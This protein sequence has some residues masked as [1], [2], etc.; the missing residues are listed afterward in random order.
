MSNDTVIIFQCEAVDKIAV[1]IW[2][3]NENIEDTFYFL[4]KLVTK[5]R[6]D[7]VLKELIKSKPCNLT[8]NNIEELKENTDKKDLIILNFY[9]YKTFIKVNDMEIRI[10]F[11]VSRQPEKGVLK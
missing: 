10:D 9:Y 1:S 8:L 3:A 11:N 7:E 4:L 6:I 2:K 5:Y